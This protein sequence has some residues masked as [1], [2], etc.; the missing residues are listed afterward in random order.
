[1]LNAN[2]LHLYIIPDNVTS[3]Y[4]LILQYITVN[5]GYV[6]L[7]SA[8]Q[9]LITHCSVNYHVYRPCTTEGQRVLLTC[10]QMESVPTMGPRP[11]CSSRFQKWRFTSK[12][13]CHR[14][15]INSSSMLGEQEMLSRSAPLC[16]RFEAGAFPVGH[17]FEWTSTETGPGVQTRR[18]LE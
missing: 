15:F 4:K 17:G 18:V 13:I 5:T 14:T 2:R 10:F 9:T 16:D 6:L 8:E 11:L 12:N 1:M 7:L 3:K